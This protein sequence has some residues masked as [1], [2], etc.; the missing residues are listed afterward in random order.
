MPIVGSPFQ[1]KYI[2]PYTVSEKS[3]ELNYIVETPGRKKT[4]Q[5]YHVNL[6]KPYYK[7]V[8]EIDSGQDVKNVVCPVLLVTSEVLTQESDG[9]PEP[10]E[11][12]LCGR[13]KNSESLCNLDKLLAHLPESK[14]SEL[15]DLVHKF[16]CLF[17]DIPSRTSLIE[18]DIDVGDAQPIK[19]HFYHVAPAI[20]WMLR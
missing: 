3:S 6:L 17:G 15:A 19:Q 13:L 14:R 4:R 9:V 8:V 18:H 7:R 16:S 10:D 5:L 12:L 1:A 20:I 11:S 2:G